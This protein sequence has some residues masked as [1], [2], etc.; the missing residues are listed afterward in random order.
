VWIVFLAVSL[1]GSELASTARRR[2]A[3]ALAQRDELARL[4]DERN[5]AQAAGRRA[6]LASALLKSMGHDLRTPLTAIEIAAANLQDPGASDALRVQQAAIVRDQVVRLNRVFDRIVT[7]A[8]ID[9]GAL[10]PEPEWV[11]AADVIEAA[12]QEVEGALEKHQLTQTADET[13]V[14]V[15]PRLTATALARVLENAGRH[16]PA[17]TTIAIDGSVSGGQLTL[18]VEDEGPGIAADALP[19][20]FDPFFTARPAGRPGLGI[21]LAIARG[22][23]AAQGGTIAAENRSTGGARF[24]LTA[25][26]TAH[27]AAVAS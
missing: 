21:G 18:T 13:A 2:T 5:A 11:Y 23:L 4:L 10:E 9:A 14:F 17:G 20:L 6:E 12:V 16:A 24:R 26:T 1:V 7:M 27:T 19:R 15:D 8:R 22:L 25:G 3:E